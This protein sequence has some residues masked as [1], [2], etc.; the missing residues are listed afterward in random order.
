MNDNYGPP[1]YGTAYNMDNFLKALI[2][3]LDANTAGAVADG[4]E[5]NP[6]LV[7]HL[8]KY[9][10]GAGMAQELGNNEAWLTALIQ[11]LDAAALAGAV[12]DA[13]STPGGQAF[14]SDLLSNLDGS[15]I[16]NALNQNPGLTDVLMEEGGA[17][18]LGDTLRNLLVDAGVGGPGGFLAD[19]IRGLDGDMMTRVLNNAWSGATLTP[20]EL[21]NLPYPGHTFLQCT[22]FLVYLK[23][24]SLLGPQQGWAWSQIE[25]ADPAG[26]HWEGPAVEAPPWP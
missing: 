1:K 15:I 19:L 22:W 12:N 16:G 17:I 10:D 21:A 9:L 18:G 20:A 3:S 11:N 24:S 7:E 8:L 4:L 5:V 13:L 25:G 14:V 26:Y 6:E 2:R 23:S